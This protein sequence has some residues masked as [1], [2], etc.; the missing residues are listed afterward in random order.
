M[1]LVFVLDIQMGKLN[2][3]KNDADDIASILNK[4]HSDAAVVDAPIDIRVA[5]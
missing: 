1:M 3:P 4:L 2:N 5:C